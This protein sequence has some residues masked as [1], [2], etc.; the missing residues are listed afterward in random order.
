MLW[1]DPFPPTIFLG[2]VTKAHAK[3]AHRLRRAALES[4]S[5]VRYESMTHEFIIGTW[6]YNSAKCQRYE[7]SRGSSLGRRPGNPDHRK[8]NIPYEI[9]LIIHPETTHSHLLCV[10]VCVCV[11]RERVLRRNHASNTVK[12][13]IVNFWQPRYTGR[14]CR[15]Q[16]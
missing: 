8:E 12:L 3:G 7:I 4:T 6:S 11:R 16:R 15:R 2:R 13:I 5:T 14:L 9:H 1:D 10:C